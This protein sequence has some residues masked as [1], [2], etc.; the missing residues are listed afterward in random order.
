VFG[1][2]AGAGDTLLIVGFRLQPDVLTVDVL[3]FDVLTVDVLMELSSSAKMKS[4]R[5][6]AASI[7]AASLAGPGGADAVDTLRVIGGDDAEDDGNQPPPTMQL[8][9]YHG[10]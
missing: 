1:S 8:V 9:G 2:E 3:T 10:S 7:A 4:G 5:H 6:H